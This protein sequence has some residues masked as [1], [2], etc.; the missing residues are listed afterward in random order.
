MTIKKDCELY[1]RVAFMVSVFFA[2]LT[3]ILSLNTFKRPR[4]YW[5]SQL[6]KSV[7]LQ[8]Q[9]GVGTTKSERTC[10]DIGGEREGKKHVRLC[11]VEWQDDSRMINWRECEGKMP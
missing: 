11:N 5:A 9:P 7:T 1:P 8:P 2:Q 6:Q 10:G 4:A 3:A